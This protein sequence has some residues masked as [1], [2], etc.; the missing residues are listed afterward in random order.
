VGWPQIVSGTLLVVLLV[1]LS[2]YTAWRQV[3]AL[4]ALRASSLPDEEHRYEHRKAWR[5]LINSTLTFVLA[6]LLVVG[7]VLLEDPAQRLADLRDAV[8]DPDQH[9]LTPEQKAFVRFYGTFWIVFLLILLA[10]LVLAA[11][12]L[13]STRRY[14]LRAHRKLQA[15]RRAMIERQVTRLRQQRNGHG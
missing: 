3:R 5:R 9:P 15:D 2:V 13:W 8:A 4:Q 14:G 1:A 12:D 7:M 11:L 6:A 10:V